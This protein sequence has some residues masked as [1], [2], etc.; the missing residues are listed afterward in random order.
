M[1]FFRSCF[2]MF[3]CTSLQKLLAHNQLL[4][5][6]EGNAIL[7]TFSQEK[8]NPARLRHAGVVGEVQIGSRM[9]SKGLF[10]GLCKE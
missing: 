1:L 4:N 10:S 3:T 8:K 5:D 9:I 7:S 6:I 2:G